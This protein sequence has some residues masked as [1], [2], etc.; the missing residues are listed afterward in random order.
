MPQVTFNGTKINVEFTES[1]SR[2]QLN[3]GE[4][5]ST[6]FG[7]IKKIFSDLKAVCFSGSYNDLSDKPSSLPANG[8]NA[9]TLNGLP[10][11]KFMRYEPNAS[12][13]TSI[14]DMIT[15]GT[16][17]VYTATP[18]FPTGY[19]TWGLLEVQA[20]GS[21]CY[22][23]IKFETGVIIN[24]AKIVNQTEWTKWE[25]SSDGGNAAT[26]NGMDAESI[27]SMS[28]I[29]ESKT[30]ATSLLADGAY[31]CDSWL[32]TPTD[33]TSGVEGILIV[34]NYKTNGKPSPSSSRMFYRSNRF[35]YGYGSGDST[36]HYWGGWK[37]IS[38]T[39]IKKAS[40]QDLVLRNNYAVMCSSDWTPIAVACT[41]NR[42]VECTPFMDD[43][44]WC[45]TAIEATTRTPMPEGRYSF[46]I[47]YI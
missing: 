8:G 32:D 24:R 16:Y 1:S 39:P 27:R 31:Y 43:N 12:L 18:D 42:Y 17:G 38:T 36:F 21:I 14:N 9:D 22:Q 11:E 34:N 20:Y 37:E 10:A 41:S 7:K 35:W 19:G 28:I 44:L 26:L 13:M 45:V 25:R 4:N 40:F 6:L 23:I 29:V 47:W 15:P 5:I 33:S 3:S 30:S 2:Q 46:D